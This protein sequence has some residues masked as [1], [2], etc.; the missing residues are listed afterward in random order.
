MLLHFTDLYAFYL[1]Q[2]IYQITSVV[3]KWKCFLDDKI[4]SEDTELYLVMSLTVNKVITNAKARNNRFS[5]A[6]RRYEE[7]NFFSV[8]TE[9]K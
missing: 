6:F 9:P 3:M 4:I 1:N 5:D 8:L 2:A 7:F